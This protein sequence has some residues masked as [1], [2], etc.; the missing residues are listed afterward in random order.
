MEVKVS[1]NQLDLNRI[2]IKNP[3]TSELINSN[4]NDI[5]TKNQVSKNM[6]VFCD[7]VIMPRAA[8]ITA[9]TMI[10]IWIIVFFNLIFYDHF[11]I[12]VNDCY[13]SHC[14]HSHTFLNPVH[15]FCLSV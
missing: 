15:A 14:F 8:D 4:E 2:L 11:S 6:D 3:K 12:R 1:D 7:M 13:S 10:N 5:K 9:I